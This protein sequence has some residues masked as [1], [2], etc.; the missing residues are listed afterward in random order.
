MLSFNSISFQ[1]GNTPIFQDL[2]LEFEL[3]KVYGII[4]ANGIGKT[5]LFRSIAGLYNLSNG[6]IVLNDKSILPTNVSFLP[7]GPFFYPY[8]KGLEY[9]NIIHSDD[10]QLVECI[11]LAKV[12][13][14]PIDHLVDTYS[15]GMKKKLA[16][17]ASYS[18]NK[19]VSIYDEPFNGVDLESNEI[20]LQ[21]LQKNKSQNI[22]FISSHILSM[23]YELCDEII[24]IEQGFEVSIY[25]PNQY[26]VLKN[27]IRKS[28]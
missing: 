10:E 24:H 15:T 26:E 2:S 21:L 6:K 20:L 19:E 25:A 8:M 23:L 22:S 11:N 3:G 1:F 28:S 4:G 13:N 12:L 5:T 27:K 18:Q 9:L 14:I 17:I 7:T 16:F